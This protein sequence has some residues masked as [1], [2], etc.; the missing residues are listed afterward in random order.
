MSV[1][2]SHDPQKACDFIKR[3]E[4]FEPIA[5]ACPAGVLTIGYG[6]TRGVKKGDSIS[7]EEAERLLMQDVEQ[8]VGRLAP[9]VNVPVTEGQFVALVS[10]A[11]NVGTNY[12]ITKC[13]KLMHALNT[14]DLEACAEEFLDITRAGGKILSGLVKR[15]KAEH[16]LFLVGVE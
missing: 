11:Y 16:D 7:K 6:H 5:Y 2:L 4:G 14:G 15:R 10:L 1:F 13:P 9:F 8:A 3:F 12:V